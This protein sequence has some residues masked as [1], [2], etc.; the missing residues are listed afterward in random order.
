M[1]SF[2]GRRSP[3]GPWLGAKNSLI[4]SETLSQ[5]HFLPK[6]FPQ[7]EN[8]IHLWHFINFRFKLSF[9]SLFCPQ[10][11]GKD[12]MVN[13]KLS[14]CLK[15]IY[16]IPEVGVGEC[17]TS[18]V[19]VSHKCILW[20]YKTAPKPKITKKWHSACWR[21]DTRM[22]HLRV[23]R[24]GTSDGATSLWRGLNYWD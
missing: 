13:L 19:L 2:G 21:R 16:Q 22:G 8:L 18:K 7:M 1:P 11:V 12:I 6:R 14:S 3:W 5:N 15:Y 20:R 4:L 23:H 17:K 24:D 10:I 9:P